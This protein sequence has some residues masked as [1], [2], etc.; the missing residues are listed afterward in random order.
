MNGELG[1]GGIH[2]M[3]SEISWFIM[4]RI[5]CNL[6]GLILPMMDMLSLLCMEIWN[7][8]YCIASGGSIFANASEPVTM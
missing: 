7:S 6:T 2:T 4:K 8:S 5:V 3:Y 1:P